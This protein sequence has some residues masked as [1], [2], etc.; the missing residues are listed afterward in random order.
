MACSVSAAWGQYGLYGSPDML[1]VPQQNTEQNVCGRGRVSDHH[2]ADGSTGAGPGLR[3]HPAAIRLRRAAAK[4]LPGT[5]PNTISGPVA[6]HGHVS[7]VPARGPVS[8][9]RRRIRN[10]PM[11]TAALDPTTSG[12]YAAVPAPS[13]MPAGGPVPNETL[14]PQS[15]NLMNQML[16][17]DNGCGYQ[18]NCGAGRGAMN[19]YGQAACGPCQ[20]GCGSCQNGCGIDGCGC[21]GCCCPWYASVMALYLNRSDGRRLWTAY[22]AGN[23]A[24]QLTNTQDIH[25][26]WSWG[27]EVTIGRR[28][29]CGCDS[30]WGVE[31][32]YWT[33]EALSGSLSVTNP[34]PPTC[35]V[36]TPLPHVRGFIQRIPWNRLVRQCQGT[37]SLA[38]RRVPKP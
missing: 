19:R 1:R 11:R 10:R 26:P 8:L 5:V 34:Y 30:N 24:R 28:F 37:T 36:S 3:P 20:N 18:N 29:C 25:L 33:T 2:G 22:D 12:Q 17:E 6:D 38:P 21:D 9:S 14:A 13:P 27:G 7:A 16:A 23:E 35:L 31:A 32:T 15:G 4:P